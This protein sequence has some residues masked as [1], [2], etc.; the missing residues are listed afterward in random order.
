MERSF[1]A[2]FFGARY[3]ANLGTKELHEVAK[4]TPKCRIGMITRGQYT[5]NPKKWYKKGYNG[6]RFCNPK[7]DRG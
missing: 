1:L 2:E 4:I 3:I 5:W 6:C 7:N